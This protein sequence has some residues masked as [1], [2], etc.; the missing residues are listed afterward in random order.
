MRISDWSSDVCSSDLAIAHDDGGD[1]VPARRRHFPVPRRLAVIMGVDVDEAGGDDPAARVDLF[2]PAG[3]VRAH[4]A[5][6]VPIPRDIRDQGL[7]ARTIDDRSAAN[8]QLVPV[9]Y[10]LFRFGLHPNTKPRVRQQP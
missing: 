6:A 5:D 1:A 2:A 10:P 8:H 3:Q 7:A 9:T 4:R